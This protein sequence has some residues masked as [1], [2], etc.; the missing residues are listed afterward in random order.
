MQVNGVVSL[1][2]SA[3]LLFALE[4]QIHVGDLILQQGDAAEIRGTHTAS[5]DRA[6]LYVA[7]F[8]D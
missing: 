1:P 6:M 7:S 3:S 5:G 2:D 8:E 4:G